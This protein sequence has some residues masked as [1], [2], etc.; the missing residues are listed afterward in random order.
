M[1]RAPRRLQVRLTP[2]AGK[3]NP[4]VCVTRRPCE[5]QTVRALDLQREFSAA[6]FEV[7]GT[8]ASADEALAVAEQEQPDAVLKDVRLDQG[9]RCD[10]AAYGLRVEPAV[11]LSVRRGVSA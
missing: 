9:A 2:R 10:R 6:G 4:A 1:V 7:I 11:E 8:A 5:E 3:L